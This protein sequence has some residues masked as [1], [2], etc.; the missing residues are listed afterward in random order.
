MGV[1]SAWV[2]EQLSNEIIQ[3][4][5]YNCVLLF[6]FPLS[7]VLLSLTATHSYDI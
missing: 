5:L 3:S 7:P 1:A 4:T 6:Y 2:P